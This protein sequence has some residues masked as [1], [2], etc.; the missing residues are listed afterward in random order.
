MK[1]ISLTMVVLFA[2]ATSAV[3]DCF[4][5]CYQEGY[6]VWICDGRDYNQELTEVPNWCVYD[7]GDRV[8]VHSS[9]PFQPD[10]WYVVHYDDPDQ[11]AKAYQYSLNGW[12]VDWYVGGCYIF[13]LS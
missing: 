11:N 6:C 8:F 2:L 7:S 5:I 12:S 9:G 4:Q 10:K 1:R 13:N 3:P